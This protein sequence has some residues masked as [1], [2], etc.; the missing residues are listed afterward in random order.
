MKTLSERMEY[1]I[2]DIRGKYFLQYRCPPL[3]WFWSVPYPGLGLDTMEEVRYRLHINRHNIHMM[4]RATARRRLA[5]ITKQKERARRL[6]VLV[7]PKKEQKNFEEVED[8]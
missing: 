1:R 7:S 6:L 5:W 4:D 3:R 8:E 2:V